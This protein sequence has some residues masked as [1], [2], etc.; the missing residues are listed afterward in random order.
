M[1]GRERWQRVQIFIG[2]STSGAGVG[3]SVSV[4]GVASGL[5]WFGVMVF[6]FLKKT[7]IIVASYPSGIRLTPT[8]L[9]SS[10][11]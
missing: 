7:C 8:I 3:L 4:L 1:A 5:C 9:R 2:G 6:P 10:G 11:V